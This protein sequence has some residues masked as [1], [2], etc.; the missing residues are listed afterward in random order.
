MIVVDV[1][2]VAYA[3]IAGEKSDL[4]AQVWEKD[5]Y[6]LVPSLWRHEF[7]NILATSERTGNLDLE[8]C[9]R[10][11]RSAVTIL[12]EGECE[13]NMPDALTLAAGLEISAYDAQY[14][15]L[16][17][18][19]QLPLITEDCKLRSSAPETAVSMQAFVG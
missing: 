5:S 14:L 19:A 7:L 11:W 2:V 9:K 4:A 8:T 3:L 18:Q 16:A 10:V 12:V 15:A 13:V 6:W 17:E 1:N